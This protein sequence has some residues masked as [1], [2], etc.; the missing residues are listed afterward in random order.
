MLVAS[1]ALVACGPAHVPMPEARLSLPAAGGTFEPSKITHTAH[2]WETY[3][4]LPADSG[5]TS[6]TVIQADAERV[7]F[8]ILDNSS[9]ELDLK[10]LALS[11]QIDA[12]PAITQAEVVTEPVAEQHL[13]GKGLKDKPTG[14]TKCKERWETDGSCKRNQTEKITKSVVTSVKF[15]IRTY[16]IHACFAKPPITPTSKDMR[17]KVDVDELFDDGTLMFTSSVVY[18]WGFGPGKVDPYVDPPFEEVDIR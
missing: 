2:H 1:I 9:T 11:L 16:R 5:T 6:V 10:K 7:C 13:E 8:D 15:V 17:L 4:E 12:Q 18:R 14:E 3:Y